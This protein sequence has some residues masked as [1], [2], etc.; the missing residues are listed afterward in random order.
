MAVSRAD[1]AKILAILRIAYPNHPIH[2]AHEVVAVYHEFLRDL[3]R[4]RLALAARRHIATSRFWPTI[5]E[6]RELATEPRNLPPF[7]EVWR[8]IMAATHRYGRDRRPKLESRIAQKVLDAIGWIR[9]CD[10]PASA[11]PALEASGR[12]TYEA[13]CA[14]A[15]RCANLGSLEA[16]DAA[17][18]APAAAL[19]EA[20]SERGSGEERASGRGRVGTRA[21]NRSGGRSGGLVRRQQGHE[22]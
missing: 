2:D 11:L 5:A 13:I 6:L 7:R 22:R 19:L 17:L 18:G 21:E 20:A 3:D 14:E 8:Q 10:S 15:R 1:I 4:D 12:K 16:A 9:I